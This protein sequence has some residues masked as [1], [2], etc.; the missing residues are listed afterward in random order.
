MNRLSF[1]MTLLSL[2]PVT[3]AYGESQQDKHETITETVTKQRRLTIGGYGEVAMTRNFYSDSYL[4]YTT[5][6]KY[7]HQQHGRFDI[8]HMVIFLGYDFG[9]GWSMGSEIEFEHGGTESAIEI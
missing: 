8:P 7:R 9:R 3:V 1:F 5:P 6:E 4:R 2:L